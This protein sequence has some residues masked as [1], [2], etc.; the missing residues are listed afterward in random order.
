I[1]MNPELIWL[2]FHRPT[3]FGRKIVF[4]APWR[5][6]SGFN[7]HPLVGQIRTLIDQARAAA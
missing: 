7:R 1:L 3:A 5:A 2:K 4:M 6:F